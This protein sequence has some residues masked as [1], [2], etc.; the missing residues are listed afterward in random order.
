[1][2]YQY[3]YGTDT[4]TALRT[5]YSQ[6]GVGRF[7]KGVEFAVI[8]GPLAR[9]GSTAANDGVN[10]LIAALNEAKYIKNWGP[11]RATAIASVFVGLWRMFLMPIDTCKTVLQ[12]DSTVGFRNMMRKV[13][14][15]K[16]SVLYQ[17]SLANA[18]GAIVGHYP[19]FYM[20]NTMTKSPVLKRLKNKLVR[21][22]FIGFASSAV[23]DAISNSI[24]VVK[25]TKQAAASKQTVGYRETIGMILAADGWKG[26]LG[27][28][29]AT[30]IFANGLQS[31]VFTICWTG[32]KDLVEGGGKAEKKTEEEDVVANA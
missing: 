24:K 15:G 23:S 30:R 11:G 28:G 27:R 7:Y 9:F 26:L 17:G 14:S 4:M 3:R 13:K 25:T 21:N 1:M 20:Y 31:I 8:Q 2:N 22:A 5:L 32:L 29:L 12:V 19:W 10:A 16:L 6:G 18:L